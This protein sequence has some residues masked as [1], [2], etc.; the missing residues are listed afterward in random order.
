MEITQQASKNQDHELVDTPDEEPADREPGQQLLLTQRPQVQF[1]PL[2]PQPDAHSL[3][4][5]YEGEGVGFL[6]QLN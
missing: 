6:D 5:I 1:P 4:C 2:L 3:H